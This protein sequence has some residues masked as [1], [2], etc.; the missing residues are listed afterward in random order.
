M[1][2]TP[3]SSQ[4]AATSHWDKSRPSSART[5]SPHDRH[6]SHLTRKARASSYFKRTKHVSIKTKRGTFQYLRKHRRPPSPG[7]DLQDSEN[8]FQLPFAMLAEHQR[9]QRRVEEQSEK[10]KE[11]HKQHELMADKLESQ[12][13]ESQRVT[14]WLHEELKK[15]EKTICRLERDIESQE[16]EFTIRLAEERSKWEGGAKERL[17]ALQRENAALKK[18]NEAF[19][20][21]S[22][23]YEAFRRD[24]RRYHEEIHRQ[25]EDIEKLKV[26]LYDQ[27]K[28]HERELA[29]KTQQIAGMKEKVRSE[30]LATEQEEMAR[31]LGE[32]LKAQQQLSSKWQ[33]E[34]QLYQTERQ[35]LKQQ[36][37]D[38]KSQLMEERHQHE[39]TKEMLKK[40]TSHLAQSR[41]MNTTLLPL[42]DTLEG[43]SENLSAQLKRERQDVDTFLDGQPLPALPSSIDQSRTCLLPLTDRPR[44]SKMA[45]KGPRVSAYELT[46]RLTAPPLPPKIRAKSIPG[47][48]DTIRRPSKGRRKTSADSD[49][50]P[51]SKE[52]LIELCRVQAKEVERLN[53]VV[54]DHA[55]AT[56]KAK[57]DCQKLLGLRSRVEEFLNDSLDEVSQELETERLTRRQRDIEEERQRIMQFSLPPI[58]PTQREALPLPEPTA[59]TAPPA[60]VAPPP[61]PAAEK[62]QT[63]QTFPSVQED[64]FATSFFTAHVSS[65]QSGAGPDVRPEARADLPT[66]PQPHVPSMPIEPPTNQ[67]SFYTQRPVHHVPSHS[68]Q[69][70]LAIV[71]EV[72]SDPS[73]PI[74]KPARRASPPSRPSPGAIPPPPF[75]P[76]PPCDESDRAPSALDKLQLVGRSLMQPPS[77]KPPD[78]PKPARGAPRARQQRMRATYPPPERRQTRPPNVP[79]LKL[80]KD[81]A[82]GTSLRPLPKDSLQRS[83]RKVRELPYVRHGGKGSLV[84]VEGGERDTFLAG[85]I[86]RVR[87]E[88]GDLHD[89]TDMRV[90]LGELAWKDKE[91][92]LRLLFQKINERGPQMATI[93][94]KLRRD[95]GELA[96]LVP[97]KPSPPL[98]EA[99]DPAAREDTQ[100]DECE[101]VDPDRTVKDDKAGQPEGDTFMTAVPIE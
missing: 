31:V 32:D 67:P 44:P 66:R 39:T 30:I 20:A 26:T 91:R 18:E 24:E 64:S 92:V 62:Y 60:P 77:A 76:S 16:V 3:L 48:R 83:A 96:K 63:S 54:H 57:D 15:R 88:G 7:A 95:V 12:E 41:K 5:A 100:Q 47:L 6:I 89:I 81:R 53:R 14:E 9:L 97:H 82:R 2:S 46:E 65:A 42:I 4:S 34:V 37:K 45:T 8:A 70:S 33:S 99:P 36:I 86:R 94:R 19:K 21:E 49:V 87:E 25:Q 17:D 74:S 50:P 75:L 56:Q 85:A 84:S 71:N 13:R 11:L 68:S 79:P 90:P 55:V 80:P 40:A 28:R 51:T 23:A 52:Q 43:H 10:I 101:S 98:G 1:P 72:T 93:K 38:I 73:T 69:R 59:P 35:Q 27:T 22:A 61:A 29:E 78:Q 58:S